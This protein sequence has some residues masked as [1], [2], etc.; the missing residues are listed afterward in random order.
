M[1]V[2]QSSNN[3]HEKKNVIPVQCLLSNPTNLMTNQAILKKKPFIGIIPLYA[4]GTVLLS[5]RGAA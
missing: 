2:R 4:K 1:D 5:P 3:E